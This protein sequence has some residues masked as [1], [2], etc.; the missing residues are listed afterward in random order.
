MKNSAT[1]L[2][3]YCIV[4]LSTCKSGS[5]KTDMEL[6]NDTAANPAKSVIAVLNSEDPVLID[7]SENVMYPLVNKLADDSHESGS[8]SS[9]RSK[10]YWNII[11]YNTATQKYHLLDSSRKMIIS[12]YNTSYASHE[13]G[14]SGSEGA[15]EVSSLNVTRRGSYIFYAIAVD[16]FNKNGMLDDED[17]DYLFISDKE[18]NNFKQISPDSANVNSWELIEKTGKVLMQTV[19]DGNHDKKFSDDAVVIPYI[20]DLKKGGAAEQVFN[21][22]FSKM[23]NDLHRK[24]WLVK[25]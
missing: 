15:G 22:K 4:L 17:P 21:L 13:Y 12:T 1:L 7:S 14:Y 2:A 24:L 19:K 25:K 23:V 3:L 18:G 8:F 6:Y 10:T 9:G 16:D 11:F 5:P 20:Y